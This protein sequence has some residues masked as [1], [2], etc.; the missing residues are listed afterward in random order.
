M[1]S[2]NVGPNIMG[3]F[4]AM[5][6]LPPAIDGIT[7]SARSSRN[8]RFSRNS[9]FV[10]ETPLIVQRLRLLAAHAC[11]EEY[12]PFALWIGGTATLTEVSMKERETFEGWIA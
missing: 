1:N 7:P 10:V 4:G 2:K 9:P 11:A 3:I 8:F 12:M 5:K 6:F